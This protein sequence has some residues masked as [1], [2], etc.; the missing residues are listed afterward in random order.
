[1][2][3]VQQRMLKIFGSEAPWLR[4]RRAMRPNRDLACKLYFYLN[5]KGTEGSMYYNRP[6]QISFGT[7]IEIDVSTFRHIVSTGC[8]QWF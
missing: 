4:L 2:S 1:M 8:M 3:G 6:Q 7:R 5:L